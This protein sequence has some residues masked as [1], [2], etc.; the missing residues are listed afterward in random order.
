LEASKKELSRKVTK[1]IDINRWD[2]N[3]RSKKTEAKTHELEISS[4]NRLV[5]AIFHCG[6]YISHSV[7]SLFELIRKIA[8]LPEAL[9]LRERKKEDTV[10]KF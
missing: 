5:L 8:S 9:L 4:N 7:K 2:P 3:N 1:I 10:D 6:D